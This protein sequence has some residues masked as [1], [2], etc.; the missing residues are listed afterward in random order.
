VAGAVDTILGGYPG[1]KAA[2]WSS[3]QKAGATL[4]LT[5]KTPQKI[6]RIALY[7][8]P[9]EIDNVT[10]SQL[11]FSDG[12]TLEVGP[13]PDNGETANEVQFPAKTVEWVEWK[14]LDMHGAN[15]G[16][17]EIAVFRAP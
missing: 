17:S 13:L 10:R 14:A 16:L 5:W 8:R 9:N 11:T 3:G 15:S 7:D 1:N 12:T 6:N 4:R 2:E